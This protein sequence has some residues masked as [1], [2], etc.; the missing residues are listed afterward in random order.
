VITSQADN[1]IYGGGCHRLNAISAT[2]CRLENRLEPGEPTL[3]E[4]EKAN[5]RASLNEMLRLMPIMGLS[6]FERPN[7][8]YR[9]AGRGGPRARAEGRQGHSDRPGATRRV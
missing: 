3:I 9:R 7:S 8:P 6:I 5:T 4:S 2:R 1:F